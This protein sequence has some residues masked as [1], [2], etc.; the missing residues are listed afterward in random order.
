[1][2]AGSR[3]EEHTIAEFRAHYLLTGNASK[4]ARSV[5]ISERTGRQLATEAHDDLEFA[6]A[7]RKSRARA[8]SDVARILVRNVERADDAIESTYQGE[9]QTTWQAARFIADAHKS[10]VAAEKLDAERKGEIS[11]AALVIV[12]TG[13]VAEPSQDGDAPG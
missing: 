10:L 11:G 4:S 1:M 6:E 12:T 13:E 7:C 2:T 8:L 9:V 5:G 3:T